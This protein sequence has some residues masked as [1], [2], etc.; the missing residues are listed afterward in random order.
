M[1]WSDVALLLLRL[2]FFESICHVLFGD[3]ESISVFMQISFKPS[4][5][6]QFKR[7]NAFVKWFY[8]Q[9]KWY[10]DPVDVSCPASLLI[11]DSD[12]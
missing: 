8:F 10:I 7:P 12:V 1:T 2:T 4:F 3:N 9:S 5:F 6:V 11:R